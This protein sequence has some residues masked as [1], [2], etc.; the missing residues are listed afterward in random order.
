MFAR[1]SYVLTPPP[2]SPRYPMNE[3]TLLE[4]LRDRD[5]SRVQKLIGHKLKYRHWGLIV[6][7]LCVV[8]GLWAF[9][10]LASEVGDGETHEMDRALLVMMRNPQDYSDPIGPKWLEETGRD[11]TALGGTGVLAFI[12]LLVIGYLTLEK[13]YR[14]AL[15]VLAAVGGG[16]LLSAGLKYGFDRPRP[17]LVPHF[18]YVH[19]KSFPSGHSMVSATTYLTLAALVSSVFRAPPRQ[20]LHRLVRHPAR[21][22]D[23][24]E[25]RL[26]GRALAHGCARWLDHGRRL[27]HRVLE[28]GALAPGSWQGR[29]RGRRAHSGRQGGRSGGRGGRRAR[30]DCNMRACVCFE[31][32]TGRAMLRRGA[33]LSFAPSRARVLSLPSTVSRRW[34]TPP[35]SPPPLLAPASRVDAPHGRHARHER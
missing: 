3:S 14:L 4:S 2:P 30:D 34:P 8:G 5:W 9:S 31:R 25:P 29:T 11:F 12:S 1:A 7:L 26:H 21:G 35:R 20:A 19:T 24:R 18:S 28:R 27:G 10:W 23:R 33:P 22:G 17:E 16:M 13:K 15:T 32:P 6:G